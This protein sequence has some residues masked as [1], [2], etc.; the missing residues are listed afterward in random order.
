MNIVTTVAGAAAKAA[1]STAAKAAGKAAG[2]RGSSSSS[3]AGY[4]KDFDYA[5][6]IMRTTDPVERE[7]L[8]AA[9]QAK[10]NGEGLYGS[11]ASNSVLTGTFGAAQD[12]PR[13]R[14]AAEAGQGRAGV[15]LDGLYEAA[16]RARLEAFETARQQISRRLESQYADIDGSYR[17][18]MTQAQVNAR[19]SASGNE[20]KLAALGLSF[21]N[22]YAAPATGY[23]ET[24]RIA[25]DNA[26]RAD[27]NG[28]AAAR[29]QARA[30]AAQQAAEAEAGLTTGYYADTASAA[31]DQAKSS[32]SQ[33]NADRD[34]S[35]SL[36]GMMGYLDGA[37]TLSYRK[38]QTDLAQ[39]ISQNAVND[40]RYRDSQAASAAA[41]AASADKIAYEQA[42][43]RWK[44]YGYVLPA[45]AALLGVAA[46]TPTADQAYRSAQ[47][48]LNTLKTNYQLSK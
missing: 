10:I 9:R 33:Y 12:G 44:A 3:G 37:P 1:A 13:E 39:T 31:L 27:L 25:V 14:F 5:A 35:I 34:Y 19:L 28:L 6:A 11:V 23:S 20:E 8:L 15:S 40:A 48:H 4:D 30:A 24:S 21:S 18:G 7:R 47:L 22:Q 43:H 26:Y 32:L 36:A 38:Y 41:S 45:D 17:A 16:A 46:G 2:G 42:F 29:T